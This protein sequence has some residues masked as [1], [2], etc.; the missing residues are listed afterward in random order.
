V[1]RYFHDAMKLGERCYSPLILHYIAN[2]YAIETRLRQKKAGPALRE[3]V[4]TSDSLPILRR[5]YKI[6]AVVRQRTLPQASLGTAL[7]YALKLEEKIAACFIDG[8]LEV[9]NNLAENA[10]RPLKLGQKNWLFIGN[11][12]AGWVAA[13]IYTLVENCRRNGL[14]PYAYLVEVI[15][16]MPQGEPTPEQVA[17]LTPD[18]I[19]AAKRSEQRRTAA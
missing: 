4:R 12:E 15:N 17:H 11:A 13:L 8:R 3:A 18:R 19:A 5:L 10:I 7:N 6:L 14:D 9:D 1:R 2:L 16:R